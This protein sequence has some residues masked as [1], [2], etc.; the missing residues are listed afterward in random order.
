MPH[1][2]K[3]RAAMVMAVIVTCFGALIG[4]VVYLQTV[5]RQFTLER[6]ERQQHQKETI[7]SRRGCIYD[8]T[9]MLMA[10][11]IQTRTLFLDPK[12]MQDCYQS[13]GHSL[14]EMDDA[15]AKLGK[16]I[17]KDSFELSRLLG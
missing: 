3:A 16:I 5:G 11:T 13:E 7:V 15:I 1:F 14:I 6:A 12:F 17:D 10:G 4:R 8:S 9:G 2:C